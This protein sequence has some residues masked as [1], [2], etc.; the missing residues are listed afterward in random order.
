M[1]KHLE[2]I[3]LKVQKLISFNR[4]DIVLDIGCNDGTLLK[5]YRDEKIRLIGVDPV[6]KMFK[7]K[8]TKEMTISSDFFNADVYNKISKNVKASVVTSI[9]MFY[10][11]EDPTFVK[12]IA[13]ILAPAGILVLEQSYLPTMLKLQ[14][15]D[16]ICHEHLEYYAYKQI[17]AFLNNKNLEIFDVSLNDIN[18]GSFQIFACHKGA[19]FRINKRAINELKRTDRSMALHTDK[20]FDDFRERVTKIGESL[21]FYRRRGAKRKENLCLWCFHK[22]QR[23]PSVFWT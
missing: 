6:A 12:D 10:D 2:T 11:L 1:R 14:L 8:Y 5:S 16:T 7:D 19:K 23:S 13:S 4:N 15:F 3:V 18:G 21:K 20:P 17:E 22:R 9:S